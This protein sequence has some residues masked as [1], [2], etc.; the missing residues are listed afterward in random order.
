MV[1]ASEFDIPHPQLDA[2]LMAACARTGCD[3]DVI[4]AVLTL[5]MEMVAEGHEG[6]PVGALFTIGSPEEILSNSRALILDPLAG[7]PASEKYIGDG[8]LRGTLKALAQLDGAFV[9]A[10]DGTVIAA[11][12]YLEPVA[13]NFELPLGLGSRHVAAASTSKRHGV[14]VVAVSAA[15]VIRIFCGG[16]IVGTISRGR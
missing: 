14:S 3:R 5:A 7:H 9:V 11:C 1:R 4:D 2:A 6:R 16:E 15:G 10:A 13:Q 8:Q 12:R